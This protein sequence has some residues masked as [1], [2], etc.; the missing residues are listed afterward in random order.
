MNQIAPLWM[1]PPD[2]F[3]ATIQR[4][5]WQRTYLKRYQPTDAPLKM[6]YHAIE[7]R[8]HRRRCKVSP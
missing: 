2:M 8:K 4:V 6:T 7:M 1:L 3:R 5:V